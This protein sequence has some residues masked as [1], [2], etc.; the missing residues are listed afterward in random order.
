MARTHG[1]KKPL[2]LIAI[3][4]YKSF[5]ALILAIASIAIFLDFKNDY[6][7]FYL[8]SSSRK[9][10]PVVQRKGCLEVWCEEQ[11]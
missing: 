11:T 9:N 8:L 2:A 3:I 10:P 5:T 1:K 7:P 6:T 4:I